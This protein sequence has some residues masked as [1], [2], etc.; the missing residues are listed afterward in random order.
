[1]QGSIPGETLLDCYHTLG[2]FDYTRCVR[3]D[4]SAYGTRGQC[5][6]GVESPLRQEIEEV[7]SLYKKLKDIRSQKLPSAE[8]EW[9][10]EEVERDLFVT[11]KRAFE[12]I[13]TL[14]PAQKKKA[15]QAFEDALFRGFASSRKPNELENEI[16]RGFYDLVTYKDK[17]T[18]EDKEAYKRTVQ[19]LEILISNIK[20]K[21]DRANAEYDLEVRTGRF[22]QQ[23]PGSL[24]ETMK[25]GQSFLAPYDEKLRSAANII[26]RAN[27]LEQILRERSAREKEE[28]APGWIK[29]KAEISASIMQLAVRRSRAEAKI[30]ELMVTIR[31]KML[32][33]KLSEAD[34]KRIVNRVSIGGS[35]KSPMLPGGDEEKSTRAQIEE[36]ARMFNGKGLIEVSD[37]GKT[38]RQFQQLV[39]DP[40]QRAFAIPPSGYIVSNGRKQ[41]L[42]HE[43]G[44]IVEGQRDWLAQHAVKWR[45]SR[46]LSERKAKL[47]PEAE[48]LVGGK[49]NPKVAPVAN[50]TSSGKKVPV[51]KLD[52]MHPLRGKGY[53]PE[54]IAVVDTFVSPYLGKVYKENFTEIVSSTLEHF[55]EPHLMV[56][57]YKKHPDLFTLGAGLAAS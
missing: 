37:R 27:L 57:L 15:R 19:Q 30:Q 47:N 53:K 56:H 6:K 26:R 39:M 28:K 49:N 45:D 16:S 38:R 48:I 34:V 33:T 17:A 50:E 25:A 22:K 20:N 12:K 43:I 8:E 41:T 13:D 54:E 52:D 32:E 31:E 7:T 29:R 51:Y 3:P 2:I 5:R 10:V 24:R 9:R 42:F 40:T 55:S 35:P 4:G 46:A 1:M 11:K 44:H 18:K 14:P 36:F 21:K 23:K